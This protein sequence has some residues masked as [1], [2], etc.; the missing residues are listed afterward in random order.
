MTRHVSYA[1]FSKNL[2]KYMDEVNAGPL[3][4]ER[5]AGS[6]IMLSEDEFE[7]WN[8]TIYLLQSAANAEDLLKAIRLADAGELVEHEPVADES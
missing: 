2:A 1:E 6:V 7:G 5:D 4:I 8:E 3:R